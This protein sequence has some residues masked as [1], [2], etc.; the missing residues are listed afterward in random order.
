M[1]SSTP[2]PKAQLPAMI[3]GKWEQRKYMNVHRR[4]GVF[5]RVDFIELAHHVLAA[6][7]RASGGGYSLP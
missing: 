5:A 1:N 6:A 2:T 4:E 7:Y 3:G